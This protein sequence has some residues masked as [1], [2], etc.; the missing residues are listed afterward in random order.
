LDGAA[1]SMARVL[2]KGGAAVAIFSHP[3]FPQNDDASL[4]LENRTV[5]YR[6][7]QSYFSI[8]RPTDTPR[9]PFTEPFVSWR[10]S[11]S[12]SARAFRSAGV[13]I[14]AI[15]EPRLSPERA[16]LAPSERALF[17]SLNRPYSIAFRLVAE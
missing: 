3:C 9:G 13:A 6:W 8:P 4:D 11:L 10:R 17:N 7:S 15:E 16:H 5:T 1:R 2:V 12:E 14:D